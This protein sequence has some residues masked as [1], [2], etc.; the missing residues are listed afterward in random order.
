MPNGTSCSAIAAATLS[1]HSRRVPPSLLRRNTTIRCG[2]ARVLVLI[3]EDAGRPLGPVMGA[4]SGA[5]TAMGSGAS[6][7]SGCIPPKELPILWGLLKH[8]HAGPPYSPLPRRPY[9]SLTST[10]YGPGLVSG[11]SWPV[12]GWE[13]MWRAWL[14]TGGG[15][16]VMGLWHLT[17]S[18]HTHRERFA[19]LRGFV[20]A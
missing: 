7:E 15:S 19:Y 9:N 6:L 4:K 3:V 18:R 16:I 17:G 1:E 20:A 13:E 8:H 14:A 10:S 12:S 5:G 11:Q 2:L